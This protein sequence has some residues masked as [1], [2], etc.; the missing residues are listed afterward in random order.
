VF[1]GLALGLALLR[2]LRLGEWGLWVDEAHTLHDALAP[3]GLSPLNYPLGYL[4]TQWSIALCGGS[5]DEWTLRLAPAVFGALGILLTFWAFAPQVG[6]RRAGLAALMLGACS[7]HLYWSQSARAYT[8]AQDLALLGGGL[9]V[10]GVFA[11]R[12]SRYFAGLAIA[13]AAGLAHPSAAVL[14]P[15]W[16]FGPALLQWLGVELPGERELGRVL[17]L[18]AVVLAL[19]GGWGLAVWR[20]YLSAKEGASVAHFLLTTGYYVTPLVGLSALVGGLVAIAR[21]D[22]AD[23]LGVT[24]CAVVGVL[25]VAASLFVR[26]TAQ[27]VFVALPW[28]LVLATAP[29]ELAPVRARRWATALFLALLLVPAAADTALY[30]GPRHGNRPRWS[31]AYAYV[32]SERGPYDLVVGMA[33]PVGEYYLRPGSHYLRSHRAM[34]RLNPYFRYVPA[35]WARQGRRT[36][37]VVRREDLATWEPE[38]RERILE[39]LDEQC[40]LVRTFPVRYTPR[41]L[42][43]RVY[44]RGPDGVAP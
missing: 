41:D 20:D 16:L 29:L 15:V 36:W 43:V 42:D 3:G 23:L 35:H 14:L 31:E 32:W 25:G 34:V 19:G 12:R 21:R 5:L 37:Y 17:A 24:V 6:R 40:R 9:V 8:L 7:W 28:I 22:P 44:V 26:V 11:Q 38:D 39:T 4:V 27:Y 18:G 30:F 33:A 13:A 2:F 1:L 10:R